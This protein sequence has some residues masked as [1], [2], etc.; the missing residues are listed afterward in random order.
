MLLDSVRACCCAA[1]RRRRCSERDRR[2]PSLLV[3]ET[4]L[5][6]DDDPNGRARG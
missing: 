4:A 3:P 1:A 5:P 6:E 2:V